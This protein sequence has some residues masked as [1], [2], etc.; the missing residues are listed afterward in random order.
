[1]YDRILV[2]TDGSD[3][4]T[5][6]V[7]TAIE[8]AA[9]FDASLHVI[10]VVELGELPPGLEEE[11][12]DAFARRGEEVLAGAEELA[13]AAGWDVTTATIEVPEPTHRAI[14]DYA[15]DQDVDLI[16]MGTRGR[17]GFDRLA[18]GSVTEW[19]LR[20]SPIPVLTVQDEVDSDSLFT[21][22]LV[23]TDGSSCAESAASRA[24]ELAELADGTL[25]F[26]HVV[27]TGILAGDVSAGNVLDELEAE[28]R[29]AL[30]RLIQRAE[31]ADVS[32][33]EAAVLNGAPHRAIEE[34]T[35]ENDIDSI[36]MGTHGRRGIDRYLLGSVTER[37]VR[38]T[39]VPVLTFREE[40]TGN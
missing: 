35:A 37:V 24:I 25:H 36:V 31:E 9:R 28:G 15:A 27:D 22:I 8:L 3:Q 39:D 32:T 30:D 11:G 13:T 29:R 17:T 2:P 38:H 6:A 16:V 19:T 26:I 5:T 23:P 20:Q 21:S 14:L 33:I 7:E 1:M 4:A 12:A 10:H 40:A 34:Y 18:L